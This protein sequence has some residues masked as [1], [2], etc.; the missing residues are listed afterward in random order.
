MDTSKDLGFPGL[1]ISGDDIKSMNN[2]V[3]SCCQLILTHTEINL[4]TLTFSTISTAANFVNF[5]SN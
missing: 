4:L 2:H 5:N 3:L 1:N